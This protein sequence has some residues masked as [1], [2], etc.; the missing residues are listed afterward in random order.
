MIE[1]TTTIVISVVL[2]AIIAFFIT[3][4]FRIPGPLPAPGPEG[5]SGPQGET[6]KWGVPDYDSGWRTIQRLSG[7][8]G[9]S[10][11]PPPPFEILELDLGFNRIE[12][13]DYLVYMT[14]RPNSWE[15]GQCSYGGE[16]WKL[17]PIPRGQDDVPPSF[18]KPNRI[19][20]SWRFGK[21][22]PEGNI[23]TINVHR[24]MFDAFYNEVRV[25]VWRIP[26]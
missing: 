16:G 20:C 2:S 22:D 26:S 5:P 6:G 14:G 13:E 25:R 19:G 24:Y 23:N 7:P 8:S 11:E 18:D 9:P 17:V 1:Q 10:S 3:R 21:A 4:V 15:E 12:G